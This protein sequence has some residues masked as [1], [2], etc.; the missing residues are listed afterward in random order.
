MCVLDEKVDAGR[1][2]AEVDTLAA[3][4]R[5]A[6]D[7]E[8]DSFHRY[9]ERVCLLQI[10]TRTTDVLY[11]PITHGLP[12]P[13]RALLSGPERTWVLHGGDYDILSL[14]RDF[15]L[16]LGRVLDTQIAARF[17]GRPGLGL[18]ALLEGELGI[19]IGKGEQRSDWRRR[20][21]SLDQVRYARQDVAHLLPLADRLLEELEARGRRS[22]VEEECEL[23]RVRLPQPK[24][25]DPDAC[26]K[27][28]G[29]REL[30]DAGRAVVRAVHDWREAVAQAR[31]RAPFRVLAPES[32]VPI[33]REA[34][35][36]GPLPA[37]ELRRWRGIA[38][39]V[40]TKPLA[41]AIAR[42]L[43]TPSD[44]RAQR[45]PGPPPPA[46][47]AGQR[48]RVDVLRQARVAWA[49]P[50]GLEPSLLLPPALIEALA[51]LPTPSPEVL[52]VVPGM[53]RWR[54]EVLAGSLLAALGSR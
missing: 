24:V 27:L 22:W 39:D 40:D 16:A 32:I 37:D 44:G 35:K 28:K 23:L 48:A 17:L 1:I 7:L 2:I 5:L 9:V 11:D 12:E 10:G 26:L 15:G 49:E 53:T 50:L 43:R 54:Y 51:A 19:R 45:R 33:A 34:L 21:L 8:A 41:E 36:R 29:A 31:D 42:G 30:P 20:P 46:Q 13:M 18:Q 6:L 25:P 3:E 52:Q 4:P 47:P 14:Q 38:H